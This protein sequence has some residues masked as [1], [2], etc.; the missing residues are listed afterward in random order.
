MVRA[1]PGSGIAGIEG[2]CGKGKPPGKDQYDG[3]AVARP[4][5]DDNGGR[6]EKPAS[7]GA[8]NVKVSWGPAE[9]LRQIN[10]NSLE[11]IPDGN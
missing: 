6:G 8:E 11:W 4:D 10:A 3:P 9:R 7:G 2:A 1:T 5:A